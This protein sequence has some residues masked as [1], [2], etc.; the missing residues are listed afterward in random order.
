ML[1]WNT[2]YGSYCLETELRLSASGFRESSEH[3]LPHGA[4]FQGDRKRLWM[5]RHP[6]LRRKTVLGTRTECLSSVSFFPTITNPRIHAK[7]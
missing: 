3:P 7:A 6:C 1:R 2:Q 4:R 5:V